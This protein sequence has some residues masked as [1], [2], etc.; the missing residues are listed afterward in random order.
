MI[1]YQWFVD[2]KE[3]ISPYIITTPL[4]YDETHDLYLKW[5]NYQVTGSFNKV[6]SLENWELE[7]GLLAASAGNHGQGVALA[8]QNV[9]AP[10]TIFT[11]DNAPQV[12]IRAMQAYGAEVILIPGGYNSAEKAALKKAETTN[13]T[14]ISPYNEG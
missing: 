1:P 5:E 6:L 11:P 14:W 10:V 8:G 12:K 7:T 3:R 4:T 2:A 9:E 13:A